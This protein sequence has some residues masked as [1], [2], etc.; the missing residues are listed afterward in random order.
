MHY[1][2]YA[3]GGL[4]ILKAASIFSA[5]VGVFVRSHKK[6]PAWD[7]C[8]VRYIAPSMF[9]KSSWS[10]FA[11]GV[12]SVSSSVSR[13]PICA[14]TTT[15]RCLRTVLQRERELLRNSNKI[16]HGCHWDLLADIVLGGG[17]GPKDGGLTLEGDLIKG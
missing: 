15:F 5:I 7:A 9:E 12:I 6:Q 17:G 11:V 4:Q 13:A 14:V 16:K 3:T 10:V 8:F 1:W 2:L